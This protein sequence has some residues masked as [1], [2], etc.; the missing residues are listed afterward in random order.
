[1]TTLT[2]TLNLNTEQR[3]TLALAYK[4]KNKELSPFSRNGTVEVNKLNVLFVRETV[5]EFYKKKFEQKSKTAQTM[6]QCFD[7][8]RIIDKI[9]NIL[10]AFGFVPPVEV[11]DNG[12]LSI[13]SVSV[14]SLTAP[15]EED[16]IVPV[17][18]VAIDEAPVVEAV[19][20]EATGELDQYRELIAEAVRKGSVNRKKKNEQDSNES[21]S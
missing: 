17:E 13:V 10:D 21:L 8:E 18:D 15:V 14:P 9:D 11:E 7:C 4:G 6:S 3:D 5:F 16:V 20:A 12:E 2:V 1:M 19:D